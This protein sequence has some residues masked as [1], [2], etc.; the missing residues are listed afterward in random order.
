MEVSGGVV[1]VNGAVSWLYVVQVMDWND[2]ACLVD[3]LFTDH[4]LSALISEALELLLGLLEHY[5][6]SKFTKSSMVTL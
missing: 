4:L 2:G 3:F 5:R 6:D 1:L